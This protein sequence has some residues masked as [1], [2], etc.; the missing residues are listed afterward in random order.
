MNQPAMPTPQEILRVTEE[1]LQRPEFRHGAR[2]TGQRLNFLERFL[3]WLASRGPVR[4]GPAGP[5]VLKTL[6]IVL[7][8]ILV[9]YLVRLLLSGSVRWALPTG[10]IGRSRE[11]SLEG[12][13]VG[14]GLS[15]SVEDAELALKR[16]DPRT[17]VRILYRSLI[18]RL[19]RGGFLKA[20]L[21]KT[22]LTY[23][24]E[25]PQTAEHFPLLQETVQAYNAIVYGHLSYD[26]RVIA[27]LLSE[28]RGR[29]EPR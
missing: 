12:A 18:E 17:A 11:G 21:W 5:I 4:I 9:A 7:L 25:C 24:R 22:S 10:R 19:T 27:Q 28:V 1:V 15:G 26:S 8:V 23:L 14:G 13:A 2:P 16:G 3:T 29:G 20:A 6:F